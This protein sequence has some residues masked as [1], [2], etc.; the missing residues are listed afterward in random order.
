MSGKERYR[1]RRQAISK[2]KEPKLTRI[3]RILEEI[4]IERYR[5]GIEVHKSNHRLNYSK[6]TDGIFCKW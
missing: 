6:N 4:G 5:T 1:L 2:E 3:E